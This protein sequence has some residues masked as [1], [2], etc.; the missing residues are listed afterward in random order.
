MKAPHV[1]VIPLTRGFYAS[2]TSDAER[3]IDRASQEVDATTEREAVNAL[4]IELIT[5]GGEIL[6]SLHGP[7]TD[8]ESVVDRRAATVPRGR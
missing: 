6:N 8:L 1:T 5:I 7:A 4:A 2:L 3:R